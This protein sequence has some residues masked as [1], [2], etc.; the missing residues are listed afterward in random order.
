MGTDFAVAEECN[1]YT[2]CSEY[3]DVYGENVLMIEYRDGDFRRGCGLYG[4]S[5]ALVLRDLNLTTPGSPS[6]VFEDC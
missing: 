6:Y 2:E 3:I 5:H 1:R 4:D